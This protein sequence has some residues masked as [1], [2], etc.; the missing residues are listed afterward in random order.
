MSGDDARLQEQV[1]VISGQAKLLIPVTF[2]LL[3]SE[4]G[5]EFTGKNKMGC[6]V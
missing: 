1:H 3:P 2:L 6:F 5:K 4:T